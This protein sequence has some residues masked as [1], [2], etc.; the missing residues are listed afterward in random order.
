MKKPTQKENGGSVLTYLKQNWFWWAVTLG[1]L[2]PLFLLIWDFYRGEISV[3]PVNAINNRTG[4]AAIIVLFLSLA[5]TPANTI[6]GFRKANTVRKSL[7]LIAFLY[8]GLHVLNFVGLD[9]AF[10]FNLIFQDALLDKPY[11]LAGSVAV[12]IL[13]PLAITSTRGWMRRLGKNWKR[14]HRLA[15]G[16]GV[17]ATLHFLWQA[18]AA[19]RW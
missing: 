11:I 10:N 4:R 8:A 3:D 17:L 9:Y 2:T 15:Y 12:L 13:I 7:G 19:E 1:A 18:K 14:L 6:F 5:C 16:A